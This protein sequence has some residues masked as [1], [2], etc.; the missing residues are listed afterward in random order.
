MYLL[1]EHHVT[2]S[3]EHDVVTQTL[4]THR[5]LEISTKSR[6]AWQPRCHEVLPSS[7]IG[8]TSG[9]AASCMKPAPAVLG[10]RNSKHVVEQADPV[11]DA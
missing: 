2:G 8:K 5:V 3:L 4:K 9:W 1:E 10:W 11:T 7:S 6:A